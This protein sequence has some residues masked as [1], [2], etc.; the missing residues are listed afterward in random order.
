MII[1]QY[2]CI[3]AIVVEF[4][5]CES[6]FF[7]KLQEDL[8][9][10]RFDNP[11]GVMTFDLAKFLLEEVGDQFCELVKQEKETLI[12]LQ[13]QEDKMVIWRRV[14]QN[15]REMCDVCS[16]TL[17]NYHWT[18]GKCGFVVCVSCFNARRNK[19]AVQVPL[20]LFLIHLCFL[21]L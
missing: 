18:C 8:S 16:T 12:Q 11:P 1:I 17:F 21:L 4:A 7:I 9:I 19:T 6:A 5:D 3:F 15:L 14:V 2:F 20:S 13:D 10:W